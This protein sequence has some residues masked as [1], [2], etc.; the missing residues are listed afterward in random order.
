MRFRMFLSFIE[1]LSRDK[2]YFVNIKHLWPLKFGDSQFIWLVCVSLVHQVDGHIR[3]TEGN[4]TGPINLEIQ[5][6]IMM[7]SPCLK[8]QRM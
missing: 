2:A 1:E 4:N 3:L 7:N 6:N 5:V 8:L